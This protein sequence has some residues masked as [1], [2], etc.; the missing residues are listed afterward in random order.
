[1]PSKPCEW[2][3]EKEAFAGF[4]GFNEKTQSAGHIKPLHWYVACR[5]VLEG[6]FNPDHIKPRPPF[7]I[8]KSKRYGLPVLEFD[9]ATATG[10]EAVVLG[11]LKTKNVDVVVTRPGVGPV[12]AVSCKGTTGAFRN[13]TNRMEELIGDCTNLHIS[14]PTL[15]LGYLHLLR[16][17][18]RVG[19]VVDLIDADE[20]DVVDETPEAADPEVT[21]DGMAVIQEI[22]DEKKP[23]RKALTKNDMAFDDNGDISPEIRRFAL[24]VSRLAG[25]SGIRDD[26][27][28]YESIGVALVE[29]KQHR[30]GD[31]VSDFPDPA[32]RLDVNGFF[33]RLYSQYDERFVYGAPSLAPVTRR[34]EWSPESSAFKTVKPDYDLRLGTPKTSKPR[35]KKTAKP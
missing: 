31:F 20:D 7:V 21:D 1:M 11:G 27:T 25:R 26:L 33:R 8:G 18:R 5:L 2:T 22:G 34:A 12:L 6:G 14:Y 32:S 15:V 10:G 17:N 24:A 35:A 30:Y 19:E 13:L 3:S 9:P 28:R 16:A 29:A 4:A 23:K